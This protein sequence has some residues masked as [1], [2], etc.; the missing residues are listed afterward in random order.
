MKKHAL[1][2]GSGFGGLASA[3]FLA[4]QGF[5]VTVVEKN[6][7]I[8]GRARVFSDK[9]FVFD[10]GPSWYLMPDV[11]EH[12]FSL[13]GEKVEDHLDLVKLGPSYRI[14]FK[15]SPVGKVDLYSD[16]PRDSQVFEKL[17][18]G[19]AEQLK[20]YL[21]KSKFQYEVAYNSFMFKNYDSIFDFFTKRMMIDGMKLSVLTKM[22]K[23]VQRFF[24]TEEIQKIMEYQ[25]VFLGSSPYNTPALY[26]LMSHVDFNM[27]VYYPKGG[28]WKVVEAIQNIAIKNGVRFL[29]SS[30]VRKILVNEAGEATG[31]ELAG[32][33]TIEADIVISNADI[34]HTERCLLPQEYRMT[35]DAEWDKK[36]MAPSAFILYLGL[37]DTVP[38]LN[39]HNL[40][41][42]KDWKKNFG[43]IFDTPRLPEDPSFYVCC[44]SKTDT[45]V[46]PP[47][48]ENLFVLVPIAARMDPTKKDLEDYKDHILSIMEKEMDIPNLKNRIEYC[49]M[50][51]GKDFSKDYN[52]YAGTALGVAH[53]LMQT[54]FFRTNNIHKNVKN[55]YFVG[56]GTNPGIGMPMCL[57]SAELLYKRVMGIKDPAPLK[58]L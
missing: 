48:K 15:D 16:V 18:K 30:P 34:E 31:V 37:K 28:I 3:C 12:F 35:T 41:F 26:N 6:E 45:T 38:S 29:P 8:G 23:Y 50:Y 36:V 25:L 2:I 42:A 9:G 57:I 51:T 14:F 56:A 52:A 13:M 19:S 1:I 40:V 54:A 58:H 10:M 49:R 47:G 53:T 5:A 21:E 4:K 11:F 20:K 44:P 32:G 43:E 17:E 22:H 46:A 7:G 33:K 55:L 24:K 27:G 39:H